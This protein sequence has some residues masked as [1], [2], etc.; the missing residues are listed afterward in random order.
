[1]RSRKLGEVTWLSK[2]PELDSDQARNKPGLLARSQGSFCPLWASCI[3]EHP[4]PNF[5]PRFE[6]SIVFNSTTLLAVWGSLSLLSQTC[7]WHAEHCGVTKIRMVSKVPKQPSTTNFIVCFSNKN[8]KREEN[9]YPERSP[10]NN[11]ISHGLSRR[12]E[13]PRLALSCEA[14]LRARRRVFLNSGPGFPARDAGLS[15]S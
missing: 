9:T 8:R 2:N 5:I 10:G 1:M 15:F 13:D 3:A 7:L 4:F 6:N 14:I 12:K 11:Q